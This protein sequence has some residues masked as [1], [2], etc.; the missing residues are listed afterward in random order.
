MILPIDKSAKSFNASVVK[1]NHS[2]SAT[3]E[4]LTKQSIES[5][6]KMQDLQKTMY[7]EKDKV[8][9][10]KRVSYWIDEMRKSFDYY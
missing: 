8:I 3:Y 6:Q 2:Y 1:L 7:F 5:E 9:T 10:H 4:K